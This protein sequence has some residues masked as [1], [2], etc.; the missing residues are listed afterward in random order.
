MGKKVFSHIRLY[1]CSHDMAK[2][3]LVELGQSIQQ[4]QPQITQPNGKD[5]RDGERRRVVARDGGSHIAGDERQYQLC[6]GR[7]DAAE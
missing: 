5:E 2:R 6:N 3:G 7:K 1:F 4:P